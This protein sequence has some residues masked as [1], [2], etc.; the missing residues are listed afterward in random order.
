V[1]YAADKYAALKNADALVIITDWDE[2]ANPDWEKVR[3]L[4]HS[5]IVIDGR[6]MYH[7]RDMEKLGFVYHSVGRG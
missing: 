6:N 2:F 5:P 7:P 4:L 3:Q 1:T